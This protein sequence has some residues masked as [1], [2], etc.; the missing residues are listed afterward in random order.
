VSLFARERRTANLAALGDVIASVGRTPR[1]RATRVVSDETALKIAAFTACVNLLSRNIATLPVHAFRKQGGT[2]VELD[3]A[4]A[5]VV[6]PSAIVSRTTWLEQIMRSLLMRGNA[7]GYATQVDAF[8]WATKIEMLHPDSVVVEQVDQLSP[9]RYFRRAPGSL[10]ELDAARVMHVSAFNMPGS[11]VGLSPVAYM[12]A[13]LGLAADAIDYGAEFLGGG[14]HPTSVLTSDAPL[15]EDQATR[16]KR[17]FR[18][19]TAGDRL[20]VL[21][22]G[23]KYQP[24]QISPRDAQ[25]LESRQ[26]SA[27]E[28]CQFMGVPASK[29]GAAMSG[30]S[31]TY[32]NREQNQQEYAADSLLWWATNVEE[33]WSAQLP[34]GQFVRLNMDVLLRPDANTRSVILDRQLR[35]GTLNADEARA[36][37]DRPPLPGEQGQLF[38]WP[39]IAPAVLPDGS[40][41][42]AS[43][44]GTGGGSPSSAG[45]GVAADDAA[46]A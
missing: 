26:F 38:I 6:S 29:I 33:A 11:A 7:Y 17:R 40:P 3:P 36:L 2:R 25:M 9:L 44:G 46:S 1:G 21:G 23:W 37:D 35:N 34:R 32:A 31:V 30:T 22:G 16:A 13:T 41:A 5:L 24:V 15:T 27:V 4:P 20:A 39:P 10:V 28:I 8:G 19:A 18:E 45:N 43:P 14:G 42:P 12:A